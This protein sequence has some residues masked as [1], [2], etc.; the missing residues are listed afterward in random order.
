MLIFAVLSITACEGIFDE[1]PAGTREEFAE[2]VELMMKTPVTTFA[3]SD[4]YG[5]FLPIING[6]IKTYSEIKRSVVFGTSAQNV[7]IKRYKGDDEV[8]GAASERY[9][10]GQYYYEIY[11]KAP[12]GSYFKNG[13]AISY[14]SSN[15]LTFQPTRIETIEILDVD[16]KYDTI[17]FKIYFTARSY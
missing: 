13:C 2:R 8:P 15:Y 4:T 3:I 14:R 10:S 5:Y 7:E 17:R 11:A 12:S 9:T 16:G 6:A 1:A